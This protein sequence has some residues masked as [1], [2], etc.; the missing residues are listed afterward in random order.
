MGL[1]P[2]TAPDNLKGGGYPMR[3]A[4][5]SAPK[6]F[7][8]IDIDPPAMEDGQCLI[9]LE[10]WSVCGSDIRHGYGPI[11]PEEQYPMRSGGGCHEC[12]GTVVESRTS[13]F[14]EGQRVIV[15]PDRN[16]PGGLVEY[17]ASYPERMV[18]V[19]GDGTP[20]EWVMCQPS[21]T[22]LYACQQM[23]TILGKSVLIL[24]QGSIGLSFTA[25]CARAGASKNTIPTAS[26]RTVRAP[27]KDRIVRY[28]MISYFVF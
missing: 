2:G 23:G 7:E 16:G 12:I 9:R 13:E 10:G 14:N 5:I 4:R 26:A 19:P 3:A 17:L 25:I 15:L 20:A 11:Y 22:V 18:A 1:C 24:G 6:Q 21:G 27:T 28:M 8:F